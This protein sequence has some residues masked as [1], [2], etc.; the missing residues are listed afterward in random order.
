MEM[1]SDSERPLDPN[2][3]AAMR[4]LLRSTFTDSELRRFCQ[5]RAQ[6]CFLCSQFGDRF[7]LDDLFDVVLEI[8]GNQE[9]P[10]DLLADLRALQPALVA[11]GGAAAAAEVYEAVEDVGRWWA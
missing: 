2:D 9:L 4:D 10:P 5:D 11:L 7:S 3:L 1:T 8:G 6:F